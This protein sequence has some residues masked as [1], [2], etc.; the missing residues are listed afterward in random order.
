MSQKY[1]TMFEQSKI[2]AFSDDLM[3]VWLLT[4]EKLAQ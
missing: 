4:Y 3:S 2:T 1:Q